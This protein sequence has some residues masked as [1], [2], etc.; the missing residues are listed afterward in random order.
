[1]KVITYEGGRVLDLVPLEEYRPAGG[2]Y[3]PDF[4]NSIRQRYS[5]VSATDLAEAMKSGAKFEMG[6]QVIGGETVAIKE[7]SV[8][9]DGLICEAPTTNLADQILDEF[10]EWATVS[11]GLSERTTPQRRTYTNAIVCVF[12]KSLETGLGA[13]GR[14]CG[15]LSQAMKDAYGWEHEFNLFRLGFNVDPKTAPNLRATNFVLERRILT[16]NTYSENRY[17]SIAPLPTVA[18]ERLLETI[19]RDLLSK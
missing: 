11:F 14:T 9:S 1:M 17:Y 3:L 16:P 18:H 10:V 13:L 2:L 5:F 15:L 7:L 4:I 12:D 19:E 8:Y 6:K